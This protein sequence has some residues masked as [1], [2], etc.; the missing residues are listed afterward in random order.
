MK[1]N[2]PLN[3]KSIKQSSEPEKKW[4]AERKKYQ[5]EPEKK[6]DAKRQRYW[7]SSE[8]GC[9]AKRMRYGEAKYTLECHRKSTTDKVTQRAPTI[10]FFY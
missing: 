8:P 5:A 10:V 3:V 4:T 9:L 2:E 6:R 7:K 1:R